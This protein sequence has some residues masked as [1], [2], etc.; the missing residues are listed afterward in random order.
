VA[1][2][3]ASAGYAREL[4]L[5]RQQM[6]GAVAPRSTGRK[7]GPLT[8]PARKQPRAARKVASPKKPQ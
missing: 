7:G 5:L 4:G 2:R 6:A 8:E 3:D 1:V